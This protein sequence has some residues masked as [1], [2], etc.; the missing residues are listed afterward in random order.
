MEKEV[1]TLHLAE[2]WYSMI[3]PLRRWKN[4]GKLIRIG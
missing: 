3:D 2:P 1:L 4:T